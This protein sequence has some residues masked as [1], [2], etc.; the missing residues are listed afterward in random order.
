[1]SFRLR[2]TAF[3]LL[4][5]FGLYLIPEELMHAFSGHKDTHHNEVHVSAESTIENSH[6]HCVILK[7]ESPVY[8]SGFAVH[9]PVTTCS[10][11]FFY[12]S[13]TSA[14]FEKHKETPN[15]KGPPVASS[16]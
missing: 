2:I 11:M 12:K 1:M 6:I 14:Y 16:Y 13:H 5:V 10:G 15:N 4:P 7:T 9:P 8:T 3:L